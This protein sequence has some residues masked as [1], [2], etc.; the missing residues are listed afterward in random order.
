MKTETPLC[1]ASISEMYE[2]E[3]IA[4][5]SPYVAKKLETENKRMREAL[6]LAEVALSDLGACDDA[7]CNEP[8]CNHALPEVREILKEGK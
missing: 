4:A 6:L 3:G 1:D 2:L 5:V 7:D 8:N